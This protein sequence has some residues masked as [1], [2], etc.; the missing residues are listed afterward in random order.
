MHNLDNLENLAFGMGLVAK[1]NPDQVVP[2]KN[3][4][5]EGFG[6]AKPPSKKFIGLIVLV[7]VVLLIMRKKG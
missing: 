4:S 3:A 6:E 7:V 5:F 2:A 1:L